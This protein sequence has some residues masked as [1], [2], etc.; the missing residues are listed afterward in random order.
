MKV[1]ELLDIL[2]EL[3]EDGKGDYDLTVAFRW[4]GDTVLSDLKSWSINGLTLQL[5]EEDFERHCEQIE[6]ADQ[7][8]IRDE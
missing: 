8:L 2:T 5:N 1:D 4:R 7:E 6:K 3:T